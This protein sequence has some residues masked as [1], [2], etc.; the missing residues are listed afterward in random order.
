MLDD[1]AGR[2]TPRRCVGRSARPVTGRGKGKVTKRSRATVQEAAGRTQTERANLWGGSR[3]SRPTGPTRTTGPRSG[4]QRVTF[5]SISVT[6]AAIGD[7]SER[8]RVTCAKSG[9]PFSLS[10]TATT[11]S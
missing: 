9:W 2:E 3:P 1:R 10:I 8:V 4:P 6:S 7:R 5:S 11:P